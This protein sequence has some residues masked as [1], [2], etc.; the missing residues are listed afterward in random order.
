MIELE[1]GQ[2]LRNMRE[3]RDLTRRDVE[4]LTKGEFKES[5]LAMY[6]SGQ[7]RIAAPRLMALADFY[8]VPVAFLL[9]ETTSPDLI[10]EPY[11]LEAIL[12]SDPTYSR[13][14]RDLLMHVMN[15]I[16]AKRRA[17]GRE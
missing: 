7:R 6:E 12:M 11:D 13:E 1:I 14:E 16:K 5:I 2:R 15:I 17:E 8:S 4:E 10:G 3:S 9:G